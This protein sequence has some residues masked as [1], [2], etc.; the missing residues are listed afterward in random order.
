MI[1]NKLKYNEIFFFR[2]IP[3]KF[4]KKTSLFTNRHSVFYSIDTI[5]FHEMI[6]ALD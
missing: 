5:F 4:V 3:I 6:K 2:K 1:K